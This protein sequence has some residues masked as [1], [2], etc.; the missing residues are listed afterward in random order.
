M[1]ALSIDAT[2]VAHG[3]H[4]AVV[5]IG[6][7]GLLALLGPQLVGGRRAAAARDEHAL[8]VMALTDQIS[9]ARL[10]ITTTPALTTVAPHQIAGN[11]RDARAL[12]LPVAVVSSAAAAGVHAALA[13]AHFLDT[14]TFGLF[15]VGAALAQISWAAAVALRPSRQLLVVGLL[16]NVGMVLLWLTTRTIGLPGLMP[17]PESVGLWDLSCVVWELAI[18]VSAGHILRAHAAGN[19]Q[20]PGWPDWQ[21]SA[22]AWALGPA[23]VLPALALIGVG[24]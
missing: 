22:R 18:V 20:F 13:P 15:F 9:S 6:L 19:L 10:G 5:G 1:I 21:P 7:V 2:S 14:P 17:E 12:Y 11:A 3:V 8:R 24:V 4:Y 23:F 16:G